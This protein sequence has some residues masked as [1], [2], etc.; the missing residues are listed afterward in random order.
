MRAVMLDTDR[1]AKPLA[2]GALG[3]FLDLFL[4]TEEPALA[5]FGV[6]NKTLKVAE[7]VK[8]QPGDLACEANAFFAFFFFT[9]S[10]PRYAFSVNLSRKRKLIMPQR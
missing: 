6:E 3:E 9:P 7:M 8:N 5:V 1:D 2:P 10:A 4:P